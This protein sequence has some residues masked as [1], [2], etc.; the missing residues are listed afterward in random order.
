MACC[1]PTTS[2]SSRADQRS[3]LRP[4]EE[5]DR[6]PLHVVE[7]LG[8]QVVDEALADPR[9]EPADRE[10]EKRVENCDRG[11]RATRGESRSVRRGPGCRWSMMSRSSS[12]LTTVMSGVDDGREQEQAEVQPVGPGVAGDPADGAWLELLLGHAGVHPEPRIMTMCRP[13]VHALENLPRG[14]IRS[15]AGPER[16]QLAANSQNDLPVAVRA[17]SRL[18]EPGRCHLAWPARYTLALPPRVAP[19][20]PRNVTPV[21]VRIRWTKP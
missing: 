11:D 12:G 20:R 3:G 1:A 5:R 4:G 7:H 13:A 2:L 15:R 18:R 16:Y 6:L 21:S 10:A 17:G 19:P 8:A 14:S 9:G